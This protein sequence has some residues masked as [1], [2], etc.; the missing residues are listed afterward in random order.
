LLSGI[1][2]PN[3]SSRTVWVGA[4]VMFGPGPCS[5]S[6]PGPATSTIGRTAGTNPTHGTT[7]LLVSR[8]TG[9][10]TKLTY[11]DGQTRSLPVSQ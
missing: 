11:F 8:A 5:G 2:G 10:L 3:G 1:A 7:G 6:R 9:D 4:T